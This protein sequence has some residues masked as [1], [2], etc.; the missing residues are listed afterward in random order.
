MSAIFSNMLVTTDTGLE[1]QRRIAPVPSQSRD[2]RV[3]TFTTL[4]PNEHAPLTGLFVAERVRALGRLCDVRIFAPVPW[5]PASQWLPERYHAYARVSAS[6]SFDDLPVLHPR[7]FVLPKVLKAFDGGFMAACCRRSLARLRRDFPFDVID[8]H[9]ACP[10]GVAAALLARSFGVPLS[11]TVRGDDINVFARETGRRTAIQW[12][13]RQADLVIALST[14]LKREVEELGVDASRVVVVPNGVD[15]GKF[16]PVDRIEARRRLG[17][18]VDG[19]LLLSVGRLHTSKGYPV[20]VDALGRLRAQFPDLRMAIV[21]AP[22]WEADATPSIVEA[23]ARSGV[24]DRVLL[25][26]P[27]AQDSLVDWY[28]AADLFCLATTRE[29]SA[30]VLLEALSC[31]V[32]CITTPVGGNPDAVSEHS[33]CLVAPEPDAMARAIASALARPWNRERIAEQTR[34]RTWGVV[35]QECHQHLMMVAL[36]A[37]ARGRHA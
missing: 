19:R 31:G 1:S 28:G 17:L 32:P 3:L 33:G 7:Y 11:I 14:D 26:G 22:D 27:Q 36:N 10:D 18:P 37:A 23:A 25:A 4:F 8:A 9:W 12:A 34:R 29:G 30:N 24:G 35:A 6:E 20:L 5:V 21:G 15:A 16:K 2:L 13:L